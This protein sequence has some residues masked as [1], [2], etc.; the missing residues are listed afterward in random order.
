M[1]EANRIHPNKVCFFTY[2][3]YIPTSVLKFNDLYYVGNFSIHVGKLFYLHFRPIPAVFSSNKGF[4]W[5]FFCS[6]H[7]IF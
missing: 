6:E 5:A 2:I 7:P 1:Y 3:T 4:L